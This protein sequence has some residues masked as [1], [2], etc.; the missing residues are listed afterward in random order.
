MNK[1]LIFYIAFFTVL[2]IGFFVVLSKLIPGF[3]TAKIPPVGYVQPFRFITQDGKYFTDKDVAGKVYVAEYFFTT[4]TGICPRLN[5]NM[6]LVYD[7]Y[8]DED[9]FLILSHT[10]NPQT[11]SASRLK[12]YADSMK[13]STNRWVFLTG[14]KDSLYYQARLSYHIDDPKN[15]LTSIE[16]DFLHTQFFALVNKKG[17]VKKIYDGL[18][19]SEVEEMISDIDKLLKE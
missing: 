14:P 17:E 18:K 2:V 3:A 16:D 9:R 1:K 13:V 6:R 15:N 11:D 12:R 10:C 19:Q 4:C 7:R 8:K 5:N